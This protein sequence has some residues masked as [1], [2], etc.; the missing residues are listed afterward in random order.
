MRHQILRC[1]LMFFKC[2]SGIAIPYQGNVISVN[3]H[4]GVH[5]PTISPRAPT[6]WR[7]RRRPPSV[8]APAADS[9][10]GDKRRAPP[11]FAHGP[12]RRVLPRYANMAT[13]SRNTGRT[14]RSSRYACTD[15]SVACTVA[16]L[17]RHTDSDHFDQTFVIFASFF[18]EN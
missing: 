11:A 9:R 14:S 18:L 2:M 13:M 15:P 6:S 3:L 7:N 1:N 8:A 5:V 4:H 16:L 17:I 12:S 10:H